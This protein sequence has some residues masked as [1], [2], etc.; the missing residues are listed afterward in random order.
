MPYPPRTTV[1]P[2]P[3]GSQAKPTRGPKFLYL[4]EPLCGPRM[5]RMNSQFGFEGSIAVSDGHGLSRSVS[6]NELKSI[7][8]R[9]PRFSVRPGLTRQSSCTNVPRY[10]LCT[11]GPEGEPGASLFSPMAIGMSVSSQGV[12]TEQGVPV[13][14]FWVG[15]SSVMMTVPLPKRSKNMSDP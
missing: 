3:N 15:K 5:L 8:Q 13:N 7:S 14:R 12:A 9:S 1:L 4:P 10:L 11:N 6:P 2:C